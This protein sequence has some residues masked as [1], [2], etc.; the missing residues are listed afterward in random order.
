MYMGF[1]TLW[2]QLKGFLKEHTAMR[3]YSVC[4]DHSS[5]V[6]KLTMRLFG[7]QTVGKFIKNSNFS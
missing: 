4:H 5:R 7:L 1:L 3:E 6:H 2:L